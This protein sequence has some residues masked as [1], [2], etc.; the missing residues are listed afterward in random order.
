MSFRR[1]LFSKTESVVVGAVSP[2]PS[3]CSHPSTKVGSAPAE[4]KQCQGHSAALLQWQK[5]EWELVG[6]D[7]VAEAGQCF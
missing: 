5:Q 6:D 7:A 1:L 3:V 2:L 4:A